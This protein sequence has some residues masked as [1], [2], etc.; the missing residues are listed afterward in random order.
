MKIRHAVIGDIDKIMEIYN[1]GRK[2]MRNLSSMMDSGFFMTY[3]R[4][5]DRIVEK[6]REKDSLPRRKRVLFCCNKIIKI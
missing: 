4:E 6:L 1:D 3:M 5:Q 2:Y